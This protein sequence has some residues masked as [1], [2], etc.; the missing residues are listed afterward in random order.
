[1]GHIAVD[2][3]VERWD[4]GRALDRGMPAQG[5]DPGAGSADV[6]QEEL[7]QGAAANHL[8][9]VGVLGPPHGIAPGGGAVSAG[10]GEDRLR[11]LD[12]GL[13]RTAS[14]LLDHLWGVAAE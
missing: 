2:A 5:H 6:P 3:M 4:I 14:R 10:V 9:T 12:E 11:R 7:E 13:P 8:R 1:M